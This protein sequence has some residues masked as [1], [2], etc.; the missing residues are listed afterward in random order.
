M[1]KASIWWATVRAPQSW[2]MRFAARAWFRRPSASSTF[3]RLFPLA[4]LHDDVMH[5]PV[6]P[7][8]PDADDVFMAHA[9]REGC[10]AVKPRDEAGV[11]S[12]VHAK[13]LDRNLCQTLEREAAVN[14]AHRALAKDVHKDKPV[15]KRT[16]D[17]AG[18]GSIAS[19]ICRAKAS[20]MPGA[21]LMTTAA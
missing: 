14:D 1:N 11:R 4:Q 15:L 18:W 8:A 19:T 7:V 3:R 21:W 2:T 12:E 9:L 10:L 17:E 5:V 16:S 20:V 13:H 6:L